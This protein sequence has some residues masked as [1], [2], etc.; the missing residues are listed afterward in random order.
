MEKVAAY[1]NNGH[2]GEYGGNL[3]IAEARYKDIYDEGAS[4]SRDNNYAK[5]NIKY[6]D[7]VY[8]TSNKGNAEDY[9][10]TSWY[11]DNSDYPYISLRGCI[12][13]CVKYKK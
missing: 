11:S 4:D 6:G 13:W 10:E 8:E 1:V 3:Q 12:I 5:A 7:A 2:A 9:G